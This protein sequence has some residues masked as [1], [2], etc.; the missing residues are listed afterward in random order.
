MSNKLFAH[1]KQWVIHELSKIEERIKELGLEL[2]EAM[3]QSSETWHDNAPADVI[4]N[5]VGSLWS[6]RA[7][8]LKERAKMIA[9]Y[10]KN[11]DKVQIG[12]KV[13][14]ATRDS[15]MTV[16]LGHISITHPDNLILGI[17]SLLHTALIDRSV[18]ESVEVNG[19]TY[20]VRN[21]QVS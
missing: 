1:E 21:I 3:N 16:I 20:T 19:R 11:T 7:W 8:L 14:I 18:G 15:M 2:G 10:P 5:E 13:E 12:S 4:S 17:G 9:P 6:K